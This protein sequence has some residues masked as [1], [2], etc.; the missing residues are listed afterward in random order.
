[1]IRTRKSRRQGARIDPRF[2]I[3]IGVLVAVI[4][5]L[6][7]ILLYNGK[8][9]ITDDGAMMF[10]LG[11]RN[12]VLIRDEKV[13][14][15]SE[16][17]R[18]DYLREE[19]AEVIT[20]E[21]LATVYKLGYSDELMQSLLNAR[22][23]VYR[24]QMDR[25]GST[26]DARLDEMNDVIAGIRARIE[27]CVMTGNGEN[28]EQ[29]YWQLD[30]ALK[31][32][33]EYLRGKVQETEALRALYKSADDKA[34]LLETWT[35]TVYAPS[36]GVVSYYFDGYEEAMN[37]EKLSMLTPDLINRAV[38]DKGS[39]VWTT[40]D[41]TRACRVVDNERWFVAFLTKSG[42]L[43][44]TAEGVVYDVEIKGYGTYRG[45]ALDPII[46]GSQVV[47][48]LEFDTDIGELLNVRTASV[49]VSAAV[50]GIKVRSEALKIENGVTYIELLR[51]ESHVTMRVDVLAEKDG[52]AII[53][54]HEKNETLS[55][56][57]RY[58]NRKRR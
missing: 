18:L 38:K 30:S 20:G 22:E 2:F 40:G 26:K 37:A 53:R 58:W 32:R 57:V 49:K 13:L 43:T 50:S 34:A 29:L 31:E 33:M 11:E 51:S 21:K 19:G 39:A 12:A 9:E 41:R 47:N 54:P 42:E 56:G 15:S 16:Y 24:A 27:D 7:F 8:E 48:I 5:V 14:I 44:R 23:D 4:G 52:T 46:N 25:I 45:T 36:Y 3:I 10:T 35:E 6:L 1:M 17:A 28:L 55:P